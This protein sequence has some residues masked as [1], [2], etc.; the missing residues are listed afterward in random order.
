MLEQALREAQ[1][2]VGQVAGVVMVGQG[3]ADDGSPIIDVWVD[4]P[5]TLPERIRGVAVRVRDAGVIE[6]Q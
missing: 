2:W 3:Q 4:R 5:V 6:A 1:S